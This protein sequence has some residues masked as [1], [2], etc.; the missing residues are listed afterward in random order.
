MAG[1]SPAAEEG[2]AESPLLAS[3]SSAP[4]PTSS[5]A[6]GSSQ[7]AGGRVRDPPG[8][9]RGSSRPRSPSLGRRPPLLKKL[10]GGE[11]GGDAARELVES[12]FFESMPRDNVAGL[13]VE[14]LQDEALKR[15]FLL[16]TAG[17]GS[18][19]SRARVSWHLPGG[20]E[21]AAAIVESGICCDGDRCACGRYGRGGYVALTAAKANAYSGQD[22]EDGC[23]QLFMVLAV[24]DEEVVQ[25]EHGVRPPRTAADNPGYPT[26]FCFVDAGRLHCVCLLTYRWVPTG[27]RE[28]SPENRGAISHI[29]PRRSPW[30]SPPSWS[31]A[32]H[33]RGGSPTRRGSPG[34]HA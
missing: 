4:A 14:Q 6:G 22:G 10:F 31:P 2:A 27:R 23:R 29:V 26:E 13:R 33:K 11:L 12:L 18:R 16:A 17:E 34:P 7:A 15:R 25:G 24:P 1:T 20:P 19:W 30:H 21:A 9:A 32:S 5:P 8:A 28:K 3:S